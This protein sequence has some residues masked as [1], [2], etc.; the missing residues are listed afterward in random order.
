MTVE[1]E[2]FLLI[3]C[4]S[5]LVIFGDENFVQAKTSN[6]SDRSLH[7]D[8]DVQIELFTLR[9]PIVPQILRMNNINTIIKSNFNCKAP[10]RIIIHGFRSSGEFKHNLTEG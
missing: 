4:G 3:L 9:N 10:T 5:L 1:S 7:V 2:L 8:E 6:V